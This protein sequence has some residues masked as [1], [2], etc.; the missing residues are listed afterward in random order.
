MASNR[1][2]NEIDNDKEAWRLAAQ[3]VASYNDW[4]NISRYGLGSEEERRAFRTLEV[5]Q[6]AYSRHNKRT[7][8]ARKRRENAKLS[9]NSRYGKASLGNETD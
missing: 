8:A 6:K 2:K 9:L 4:R 1:T 5:A 3:V 7:I